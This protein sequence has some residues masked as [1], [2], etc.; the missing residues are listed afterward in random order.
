V[1]AERALPFLDQVVDR[2]G[3][4]Q[5][6]EGDQGAKVDQGGEEHDLA[7]EDQPEEQAQRRHQEYRAVRHPALLAD[8]RQEPRQGAVPAHRIEQPRGDRVEPR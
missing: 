2:D 3:Q 4:V 1:H 8:V 7:N 6:Q 5:Q